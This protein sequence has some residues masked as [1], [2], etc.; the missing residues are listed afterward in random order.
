MASK[1]KQAGR[2][3]KQA[4]RHRKV[5]ARNRKRAARN[6]ILAAAVGIGLAVGAG[7]GVAAAATDGGSSDSG[8][9]PTSADDSAKA[10]SATVAH[11]AVGSAK[12]RPNRVSNSA[13]PSTA[14]KGATSP[15]A[16]AVSTKTS[17]VVTAASTDSTAISNSTAA[18]TS[19][20]AT[21]TATTTSKPAAASVAPTAA[22]TATAGTG[23]WYF[24]GALTRALDRLT[25]WPGPPHSFVT[26]TN[27]Q[28]D[29]S[30]D[31]ADAQLDSLVATAITGSP[32]RWV[33]DLIGVLHLFVTSAIPGYTF[34]DTLN[35]W[36]DFLNRVVPPFTISSGASTFGII[37]P[38]KIM[39]AAV[40][41]AATVL[42]DML[43]N[44]Y[45]P[46]Q[47]EIDAIYVTT[48]ATVTRA[49]LSNSTSLETK[50]AASVA[51]GGG[52][53]SSPAEAFNLTL[54]TWTA[55]QVNP[56]TVVTYVALVG[57]Y[58]RFQQMAALE[59][60][61]TSTG[62]GSYLYTL[63][64]GSSESEYAAGTFTA[65]D[66]DGNAVS[67]EPADGNTYTSAGGAL[68]TINTYGGGYTYTN[69]LPGA[70]FFHRATSQNPADAYDTVNIP[71]TTAD[72]APYTVTFKI[73]IIN[74]TNSP[75]T[76]SPSNSGAD[77]LGVVRGTVGGSDAD[78]D[79]LTYSLVSSS[80]NGL[81]GNSAYTKNGTNNGGIVTL[82][83]TTGAF[84]YV[85]SSTAGAS[86]SFQVQVSDGHGGN[87]IA[88]VTV[89]NTTSVTA[90]NVNTSTQ[91]VESGSVPIPTSD[92]GMFTYSLGTVPTKGTVTSFNSATGAFT[93]TR[94]STLGHTTSPADVVTV[95][96]TDA[97]GRTVTLSLPVS[98]TVPNTP[99][100]IVQTTTN[101][102]STNS[103]Q[104]GLNTSTW[105]Q[106]TTGKITAT[107]A[108]GDT[109]TYSLV[110]PS[111]HAAT[112]TTTNGGT[113][114]FNADGT[115]T[116][117]I[118]K[119]QAYFH[120][121]AKIGATGTA[122]D[123]SF[124]VA[125]NDGFGG[126]TYATVNVPIYAAN[127]APTI[128]GGTTA[129]F[130]G[131]SPT[132]TSI[133]VYDADGDNAGGSA[134]TVGGAGYTITSGFN[135]VYLGNQQSLGTSSI[136][137][138]SATTSYSGKT[139]TL[140]VYDGYYTVA[141]GIVT[142]TPASGSKSWTF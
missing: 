124:T 83:S 141:N 136:N 119:N 80:V 14:S 74:G 54:P 43:N 44:V 98:P 27:Y 125:V 103:A 115:Y 9:K 1:K 73:Q 90:A 89:P 41:G 16:T 25:G 138:Q 91:N 117:T 116:Y 24:V 102:G 17:V 63:G 19:A 65:V 40:A 69:T 131:L 137:A 45:D 101:A 88:T 68:V 5:V 75:P 7:Q 72:G 118:T 52:V 130:F 84:T 56:F 39:G 70:A 108:D 76:A 140:T 113:V 104:W 94:N 71:V 53:Y 26:V 33:P 85:S 132:V 8:S 31:A 2:H 122:V 86:Q 77:A 60:F 139:V 20:T 58:K 99:P 42:T 97:N 142:G 28:I 114:T 105:T 59:T 29:Q 67:F 95:I 129:S 38:Y 81:S 128:S 123:D 51:L 106:T 22:A 93:Y 87:T 13:S 32:A 47:W 107:D 112:T 12:P 36:G 48:G 3:R 35:A 37:T 109:L 135:F 49:D 121:A 23:P 120:G 82:N 133:A 61:T 134:Y 6:G 78:G 62:Y 100:A 18:A 50:I 15:T 126:T 79:T 34:S 57:L 55:A 11:G 92:A 111:T 96:A 110:N 66:Q 46:A 10:S 64:S 21:S 4:A 127:T 30:L